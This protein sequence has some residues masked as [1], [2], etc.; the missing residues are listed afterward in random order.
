MTEEIRDLTLLEGVTIV[1]EPV[2][3]HEFNFE[4]VSQLAHC[5]F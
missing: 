4:S 1:I 3:R 5:F 2:N